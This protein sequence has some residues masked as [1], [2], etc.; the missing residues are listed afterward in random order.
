[1]LN[2][3][4]G[5]GENGRRH[6]H[7]LSPINRLNQTFSVYHSEQFL[8]IHSFR[9]LFTEILYQYIFLSTIGSNPGNDFGS[10]T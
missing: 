5:K 6:L 1:M 3:A 8:R 4:A 2:S 7:L 10:F 9:S